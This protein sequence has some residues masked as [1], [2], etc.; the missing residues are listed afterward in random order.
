MRWHSTRAGAARPGARG[1][2]RV[3]PP[4]RDRRGRPHGRRARWRA[5]SVGRTSFVLRHDLHRRG[6]AGGDRPHGH[7]QGRRGPPPGADR[8]TRSGAAAGGAGPAGVGRRM[9]TPAVPTDVTSPLPSGSAMPL[10]GFGTWQITGPDRHR[11]HRLGARGRL[12]PPRHRHRLRQR[13]RGRPRA[14]PP[15]GVDRREV[16]LTTKCPPTLADTA[17]ETLEQSLETARHRPRRPLADPLDARHRRRRGPV[18][19]L[20]AGPRRRPRPRHRRQQLLASR[21][22]TGSRR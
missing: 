12:P 18:D 10:L 21:R 20:R 5:E 11:V 8:P 17:R 16:F 19:D 13:G 9:S 2:Q 6:R 15:S 14:S 1:P 3:R 22:S 7:G 4:A